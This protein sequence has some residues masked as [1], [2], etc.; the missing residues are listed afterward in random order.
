MS[1]KARVVWV[2]GDN[3]DTDMMV[4]AYALQES[5]ENDYF[6]KH[7]FER[8][9]PEF[10]EKC[11]GRKSVVVGGKNFGCGSSREQ[12]VYALQH[13]GIKAVIAQSFP[14]I[15]YRNC[16]NNGLPAIAYE[17]AGGIK[18]GDEVE[19]DLAKKTI[20]INGREEE[21]SLC[22]TDAALLR[23]GGLWGLARERL[24]KKMGAK[25]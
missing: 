11:R 8:S 20:C 3:V 5:W 17:K 24:A 7:A 6:A 21:F 1:I 18:E 2:F 4:P 16:V 13:N 12:A 9:H 23:E 15:F 22:E 19:I 10:R 25:K 14:D